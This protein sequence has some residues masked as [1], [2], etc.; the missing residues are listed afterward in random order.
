[1]KWRS[2]VDIP[3]SVKIS[4]GP[5]LAVLALLV[6]AYL[7]DALIGDFTVKTRQIGQERFEVSSDLLRASSDLNGA[8]MDLYYVLAAA[9]SGQDAKTS[10]GMLSAVSQRLL[11]VKESISTVRQRVKD[12]ATAAVLVKVSDDLS[13]FEQPI[14][15][16]KDMLEI[17][18]KSAVSF[19]EPLRENL[20]KVQKSLASVTEDQRIQA[21]SMV[22]QLE[23]QGSQARSGFMIVNAVIIL[24]LA[25]LTFTLLR[26]LL[27]SISQIT[28]TT[29][30]LANGNLQVDIACL[31]RRDELGDIVGALSIFRDSLEATGRL[32]KEREEAD[33]RL[34]QEKR[35][36]A[37]VLA[38]ELETS[39]QDLVQDLNATVEKMEASATSLDTQSNRGQSEANNAVSAMGAADRNV[40]AVAGAAEELSSSFIEIS[41]QVNEG[42]TITRAS[43]ESVQESTTKMHQLSDQANQIGNIVMLIRDI[44][45][46]TNLLALNATIEAARAGDAGKGFAVVANEVKNLANQTAKATEE[47]SNQI[48]QMQIAANEAS[49]AI[50]AVKS[51]VDQN[52]EVAAAIA[53]AVEEQEAA[54]REIARNI[55]QASVGTKAVSGNIETLRGIVEHTRG[56]SGGLLQASAELGKETTNLRRTMAEVI[57]RLRA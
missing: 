24:L 7:V 45:S 5:A 55:Q 9:D 3:L 11:V 57:A 36:A 19:L 20:G 23:R 17:D 25:V 41:R 2:V 42:S 32:Q 31:A 34:A 40:Q 43:I 49:E 8:I 16:L 12:D 28:R 48:S 54:T 47:I 52:V 14:S 56:S 44:A 33:L 13:K 38:N 10:S 27:G 46:Q 6:S 37:M 30:A 53:V 39:L 21:A 26:N 1:M 15:F 22:N 51:T 18:P 4:F 35:Q 29:T 50:G